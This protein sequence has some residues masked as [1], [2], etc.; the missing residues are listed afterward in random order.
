MVEVTDELVQA[1]AGTTVTAPSVRCNSTGAT[2]PKKSLCTHSLQASLLMQLKMHWTN[3]TETLQINSCSLHF[4]LWSSTPSRAHFNMSFSHLPGEKIPW[5]QNF[6]KALTKK[7]LTG[8]EMGSCAR[9]GCFHVRV[10]AFRKRRSCFLLG[11]VGACSG[12]LVL[13]CVL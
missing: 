3:S 2:K 6:I 7:W 5:L 8:R 10:T 4:Y 12:S 13:L 9:G 11:I 1:A